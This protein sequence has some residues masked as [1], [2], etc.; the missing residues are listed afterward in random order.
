[1]ASGNN[2]ASDAQGNPCRNNPNCTS[3]PNRGPIT[4]GN[5]QWTNGPTNTP[6]GRVLV[7]VPGTNTNATENRTSIRSHSCVNPFGPGLGPRF[8]SEGCI[9]GTVFNIQEPNRVLDAEPGSTLEVAP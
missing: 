3:V 1:V 9:T 2:A 8:C 5:W 7:P 6:N 4:T